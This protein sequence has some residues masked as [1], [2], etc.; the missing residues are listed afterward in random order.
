MLY[1]YP[2]T[3]VRRSLLLCL[4]VGLSRASFAVTDQRPPPGVR[5]EPD[6]GWATIWMPAFAGMTSGKYVGFPRDE[7]GL[8][9][10]S[11]GGKW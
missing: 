2:A 7:I 9:F 5:Q 4:P 6:S 8:S 11:G 3:R 10:D 1:G